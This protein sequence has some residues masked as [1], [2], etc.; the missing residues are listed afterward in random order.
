MR[1]F[2]L[3]MFMIVHIQTVF[4]PRVVVERL[5]IPRWKKHLVRMGHVNKLIP[6]I[7][8]GFLYVCRVF[9]SFALVPDFML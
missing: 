3:Q 1:L 4:V 5:H 9:N 8:T 2:W 7:M 6:V